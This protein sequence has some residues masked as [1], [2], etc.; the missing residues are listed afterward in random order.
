VIYAVRYYAGVNRSL[1]FG[2]AFIPTMIL[3]IGGLAAAVMAAVNGGM[4]AP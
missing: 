3:L 1:G 4:I 2:L